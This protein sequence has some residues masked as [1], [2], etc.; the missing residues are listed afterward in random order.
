MESLLAPLLI[1]LAEH[2]DTYA[3]NMAKLAARADVLQRNIGDEVQS[4]FATTSQTQLPR[5]SDL[6]EV[7]LARKALV[8]LAVLLR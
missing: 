7:Y 4:R 2:A 6:P 3:N 1:M 8:A 5:F